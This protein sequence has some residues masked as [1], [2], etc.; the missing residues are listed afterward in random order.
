[1]VDRRRETRVGGRVGA[2]ASLLFLACSSAPPPKAPKPEPEP[3]PEAPADEP[4]PEKQLAVTGAGAALE[5]VTSEPVEETR[6]A[7]SPDGATLLFEVRV[8]DEGER[9]ARQQTLVA[10]NPNTRAQRTLYTVDTNESDNPAWFPDQSS[11]VYASDA[12]GSWSLVRALTSTPNAAIAVLAS[13]EVAPSVSTPSVS[14]DGSR[15]AFSMMVRDTRTIAVI[16]AD[17]SHLT[18]LGGGSEPCWNPDGSTIVFART[19]GDRTQLFLVNPN[20]GTDVVQLTSGDFDNVWPAWSPDGQYVV[21]TSDRGWK[22]DTELKRTNLYVIRR[23]GTDLTQLTQGDSIVTSPNWGR[24]NW[25]YFASDQAGNFDI[26]RLRLAGKYSNL[27][28][29]V[30]APT[31]T[32]AHTTTESG[33]S[34]DTDCKGTRIC[35]KHEC[36]SPK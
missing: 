31:Q 1:M 22:R 8:R 4:H 28:P 13:G 17:G 30:V 10:V 33:C 7:I 9:A 5:R 20:S 16:N 26:W 21:F 2:F 14:P 35:V 34:K 3:E 36:V 18:L 32:G 29:A 23:D 25:V 11:Y 27:A 12:P 6:P 19:V 24:D 15:I